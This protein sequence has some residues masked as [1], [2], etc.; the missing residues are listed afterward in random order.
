[1]QD[2]TVRR[3]RAVAY[4]IGGYRRGEYGDCSLVLCDA[5][6]TGTCLVGKPPKRFRATQVTWSILSFVAKRH[7]VL[8]HGTASV[9]RK[10]LGTFS[11]V[12]IRLN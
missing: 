6:Y 2:A 4:C 12:S 8:L 3:D 5:M 7:N 1:M 11:A 10:T 9:I